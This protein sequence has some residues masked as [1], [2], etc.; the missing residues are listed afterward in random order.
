MN[1]RQFVIYGSAALASALVTGSV[2]WWRRLDPHAPPAVDLDDGAAY[3]ARV[4]RFQ[5][6][7]DDADEARLLALLP[8]LGS[9]VSIGT[10]M[11]ALRPQ[12]HDVASLRGRLRAKLLNGAAGPEEAFERLRERL[13]ERV[14]QDY[15]EDRVVV[16]DGWV[17]SETR[18]ELYLLASLWHD[19]AGSAGSAS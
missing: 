9:A 6:T 14:A 16:V 18:V 10:R 15:L 2:V 3:A 7:T 5:T 11:R 4:A 13:N 1:R 12:D 19:R 17:L 8:S